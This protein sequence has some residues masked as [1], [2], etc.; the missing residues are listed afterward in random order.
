MKTQMKLQ[1]GFFD[2]GIALII[3]AIGGGTSVAVKNMHDNEDQVVQTTEYE[4][5]SNKQE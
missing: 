5:S 1:R 3:L 2:L 4:S